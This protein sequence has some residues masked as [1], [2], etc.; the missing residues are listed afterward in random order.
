LAALN[1]GIDTND[2]YYLQDDEAKMATTALQVG[3]EIGGEFKHN[4]TPQLSLNTEG[5]FTIRE[6]Q[7][8]GLN[9]SSFQNLDIQRYF[10]QPSAEYSMGDIANFKLS[11]YATHYDHENYR[12]YVEYEDRIKELNDLESRPFEAIKGLTGFEKGEELPGLAIQKEE[13][14]RFDFLANGKTG[15]L[16]WVTGTN[17]G[18]MKYETDNISGGPKKRNEQSAFVQ[19][20]WL[21][22]TKTSL[23]GGIRYEHSDAYGSDISPK[24][25]VMQKKEGVIKKDDSFALRASV[26]KGYRAPDF[27]ELYYELPYSTKGMA[28]IGGEYL[29]EF[30]PW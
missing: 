27:K 19:T 9:L 7:M 1:F 2:G 20:E 22:P 29:R 24:L 8:W 23:V 17:I 26:A 16:L 15:S 5:Q 21:L 10:I 28:I 6:S 3:Y 11:F 12:T 18:Q 14:E 13:L 25:T 4:I 30:A